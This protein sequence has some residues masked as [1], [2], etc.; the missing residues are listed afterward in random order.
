MTPWT[1]VRM[2]SEGERR[3]GR[4]W[5]EELEKT[6]GRPSG[7]SLAMRS[8]CARQTQAAGR[9]AEGTPVAASSGFPAVAAPAGLT[10]SK[11]LSK[12]DTYTQMSSGCCLC[13]ASASRLETSTQF[14]S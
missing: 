2:G 11:R 14:A 1:V 7:C 13:W 12:A 10:S 8:V 4:G 6:K 9:G 3:G 5:E